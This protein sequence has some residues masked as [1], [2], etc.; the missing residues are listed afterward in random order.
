MKE[1]TD[2]E[3]AC[4]CCGKVKFDNNSKEKHEK[5]IYFL[6]WHPGISSACR[7]LNHNKEIGSKD[8][9]AHVFTVEINSTGIDY[10]IK[11][12]WERYEVVA[13]AI[14]AGFRRIGVAKTFVH[15]DDQPDKPKPLIWLY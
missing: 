6:S 5:L 9:S 8:T 1:L 10:K 4:K 14:K 2:Q 13:A 3:L 15:V 12:S 7:C 11:N